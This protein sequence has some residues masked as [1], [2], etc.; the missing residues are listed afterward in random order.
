[1]TQD[2]EEQ[3]PL[4]DRNLLAIQVRW[5]GLIMVMLMSMA[6]RQLT[7]TPRELSAPLVVAMALAACNMIYWVHLGIVRTEGCP[8]SFCSLC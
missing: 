6:S 7:G 1:M 4:I 8:T 5:I 2:H 3:D